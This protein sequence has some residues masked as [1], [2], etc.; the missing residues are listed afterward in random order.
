MLELLII[1][2][3]IYPLL[4]RIFGK[5]KADIKKAPPA[6]RQE[7]NAGF[8]QEWEDSLKELEE[9]FGGKRSEPEPPKPPAP[10]EVKTDAP[11][12][13]QRTETRKEYSRNEGELERQRRLAAF[14]PLESDDLS[15]SPLYSIGDVAEKNEMA[16]EYPALRQLSDPKTLAESIIIKEILD[17]PLALR[18]R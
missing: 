3:I 14:T 9:L 7:D 16:E 8:E 18:H 15:S 10:V 11:P 4:Q 17:K 13:I 6:Q 12:P 2:F 1:I 5:K